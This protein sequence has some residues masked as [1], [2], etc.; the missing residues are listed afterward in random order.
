MI[1]DHA[2]AAKRQIFGILLLNW[3]THEDVVECVRSIQEGTYDGFRIYVLDNGSGTQSLHYIGSRL[4]AITIIENR[5]NLGFTGGFNEGIRR[6]LSDQVDIICVL[7]NDTRLATDF[8][9]NVANAFRD[10]DIA[11][12]SPKELDYY[13]PNVLRFAGGRSGPVFDRRNGY[14]ETDGEKFSTSR[15]TE[16]LCGPAM[17]FRASTLER[18]GGFDETLF[19]DH[20]DRE[21]AIRLRRAGMRIRYVPTAR[22]WHKGAGSTGG[23]ESPLSAFFGVR[24]YLI[25]ALKHGTPMQI[26]GALGMATMYWI[27]SV[28]LRATLS[29]DTRYLTGL[30]WMMQ[31]FLNPAKVPSCQEIA[32]YLLD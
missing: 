27:P 3:N 7:N 22:V 17:I 30:K 26:I 20:E 25:V 28:L 18:L 12:V 1:D 6:A 5:K 29:R 15:D 10:P 23:K 14:G 24:N 31:W 16:M 19:F 8:F 4:S 11:A 21:M 9:Q 13:A 2:A 32:S